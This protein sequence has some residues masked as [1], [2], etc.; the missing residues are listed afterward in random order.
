VRQYY[1]TDRH[2]RRGGAGAEARRR[3]ARRQA[4]PP[5]KP[6]Q[7]VAKAGAIDRT[8]ANPRQHRGAIEHRQRV[9]AG[10]DHPTQ[11]HQDAARHNHEAGAKPVHEPTF[12]RHQP[13]LGNDED[14]ECHLDG[15]AAPVMLLVYR[16]DEQVPTILQ[17]GDHHH[18]DDANDELGDG[19][20]TVAF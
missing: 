7:R 6:F 5:Y 17:I 8:R 10:V 13:C 18:A 3:H 16:V 2:H 9:G 4:A 14:A 20:R 11:R 1:F 19:A 15:G 12:H